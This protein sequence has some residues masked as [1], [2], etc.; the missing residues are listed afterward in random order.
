MPIFD[1]QVTGSDRA[2]RALR[3]WAGKLSNIKAVSP[4]IHERLLKWQEKVF[5]TE[6]EVIGEKWP[7]YGDA[8]PKEEDYAKVKGDLLNKKP[9]LLRFGNNERLFPSLTSDNAEHVGPSGSEDFPWEFGTKVPYAS[10]HQWGGQT[11]RVHFKRES[12]DE[13]IKVPQRMF[14]KIDENIADTIATEIRKFMG[15]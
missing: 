7:G 1:I 8:D 10:D 13:R 12:F 14:L 6:G 15:L 5:E 3:K 9:E 11:R 4:Q 2:E